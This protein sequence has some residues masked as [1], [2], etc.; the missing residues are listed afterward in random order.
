MFGTSLNSHV[1]FQLACLA[2]FVLVVCGQDAINQLLGVTED[3]A[4]PLYDLPDAIQRTNAIIAFEVCMLCAFGIYGFATLNT[5]LLTFVP[6]T[7][8]YFHK[9]K[10]AF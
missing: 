9:L 7:W 10:S 8:N 6:K 3:Q 5:H 4:I 1:V 2:V